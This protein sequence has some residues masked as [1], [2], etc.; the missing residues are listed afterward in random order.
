MKRVTIFL[1]HMRVAF[2]V[3]EDF[4]EIKGVKSKVTGITTSSM[5]AYPHVIVSLENGTTFEYA[6]VPFLIENIQKA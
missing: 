3:G 6:G 5:R 2:T 1:P 4:E